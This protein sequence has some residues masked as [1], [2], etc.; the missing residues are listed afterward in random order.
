MID[1]KSQTFGLPP[2]LLVPIAARDVAAIE[3][4]VGNLDTRIVNRSGRLNAFVVL[5]IQAARPVDDS[6]VPLWKHAKA[7]TFAQR[8]H[9]DRQ[10]WVHVD[11][12]AYR[13]AYLRLGMPAI[14]AGQ[15]LD[16][17]QNRVA[18]RLRNYSHPYLRLCPVSARVNTSGGVD[19]GG[20]G[21]EKDF[22]R[23]LDQ[24]DEVIQ[25]AAREAMACYVIYADPMDLTKMLNAEPGTQVLPG[26]GDMLPLF[27]P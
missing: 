8:L 9:P 5:P 26:V 7:A 14:R 1:R 6:A 3:R 4:Y 22:L 27:Y 12:S 2:S 20:E 21:M 24:Q 15:V 25:A 10:V 23:T 19:A 13:S 16:H 18:I 17:I 11:Y